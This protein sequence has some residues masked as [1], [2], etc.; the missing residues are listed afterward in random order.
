MVPVPGHTAG[1][2]VVLLDDGDAVVGDLLRG[3]FAFARIRPHHPV[4]HFSPRT[5]PVSVGESIWC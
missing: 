4:R 1:S 5:S 3:G 2:C